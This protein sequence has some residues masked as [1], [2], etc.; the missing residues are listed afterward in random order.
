MDLVCKISQVSP[1]GQRQKSWA[2]TAYAFTTYSNKIP[3]KHDYETRC[4]HEFHYE[5]IGA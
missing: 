3:Q 1:L 5:F 4:S 2:T